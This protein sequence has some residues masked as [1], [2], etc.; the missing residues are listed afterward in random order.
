MRRDI[1][2]GDTHNKKIAALG[3]EI[4]QPLAR[5]DNVEIAGNENNSLRIVRLL[6]NLRDNSCQIRIF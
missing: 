2:A 6:H 3:G 4:Q 5:M 1:I